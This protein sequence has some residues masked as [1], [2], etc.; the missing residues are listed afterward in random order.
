MGPIVRITAAQHW[1]PVLLNELTLG[2]ARRLV[3]I[4]K[5]LVT[6]NRRGDECRLRDFLLDA[7]IVGADSRLG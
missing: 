1:Q 4:T 5:I 2:S 6:K 7:A 3:S